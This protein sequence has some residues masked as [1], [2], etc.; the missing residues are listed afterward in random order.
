MTTYTMTVPVP[1]SG[2]QEEKD[3][4]YG[5]HYFGGIDSRCF[6]C[7]SKPWHKAADYPCGE[8]VPRQTITVTR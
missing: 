5:T 3:A 1:F 2:T 8:S 4:N 7:D 6:M